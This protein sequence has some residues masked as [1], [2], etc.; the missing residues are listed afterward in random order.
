M[1]NI[2]YSPKKGFRIVRD[3]ELMA[4]AAMKIIMAIFHF[5]GGDW[6]KVFRSGNVNHVSKPVEVSY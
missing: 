6:L 3:S 2:G 4:Y 5:G 1:S